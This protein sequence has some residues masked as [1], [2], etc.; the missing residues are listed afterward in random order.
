M[1]M[2]RLEGT[3][4]DTQ[5]GGTILVTHGPLPSYVLDKVKPRLH[6]SGHVHQNYG[7]RFHCA[8]NKQATNAASYRDNAH[9]C[10]VN[11]SV[12]NIQYDPVNPPIVV[13]L[14]T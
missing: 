9:V 4:L 12:M 6:I 10:C 5:K 11:A 14:E 13:D 8:Q 2:Q 3:K 7:V 1:I